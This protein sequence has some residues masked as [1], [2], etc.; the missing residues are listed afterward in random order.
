MSEQSW[1]IEDFEPESTTEIVEVP[2]EVI[3]PP[4]VKSTIDVERFMLPVPVNPEVPEIVRK[5][6]EQVCLQAATL[7]KGTA[8]RNRRV[9]ETIFLARYNGISNL[10]KIAAAAGIHRN[11]ITRYLKWGESGKSWVFTLFWAYWHNLTEQT[12]VE[13]LG[14]LRRSAVEPGGFVAAEKFL[15]MTQ[16]EEYVEKESD[17]VENQYNVVV[18]EMADRI[19]KMDTPALQEYS[20]RLQSEIAAKLV[21]GNG[22]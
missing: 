8:L 3:E 13:V 5:A 6:A 12:H 2:G 7:G 11:L 10:V 17:R 21:T 15:K 14:N 9:V 1:L 20:R 22:S 19:S 16:K 18:L 4:A